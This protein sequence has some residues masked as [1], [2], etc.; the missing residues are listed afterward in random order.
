MKPFWNVQH[1]FQKVIKTIKSCKSANFEK[2]IRENGCFHHNEKKH[3]MKPSWDAQHT[4]QKVMK[5]I[6]SC[7]ST[8]LEKSIRVNE[9][10]DHNEKKYN[11][12]ILTCQ[13]SS[14]KSNE[15]DEILQIRKC[16]FSSLLKPNNFS[17][18]GA[19]PDSMYAHEDDRV[20]LSE[21]F[22]GFF[23]LWGQVLNGLILKLCFP[24]CHASR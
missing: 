2:S 15:K 4:F 21:R 19:S 22:D 18:H 14:S 8:N 10:I 5:R 6:K 1:T 24:L 20:N 9:Y 13:T 17:G 11:E 3:K 23:N 7:K 12:T 16:F